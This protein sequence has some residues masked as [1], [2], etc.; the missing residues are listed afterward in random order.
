MLMAFLFP[1][2]QS[3]SEELLLQQIRMDETIY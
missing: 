1:D 2:L 3:R